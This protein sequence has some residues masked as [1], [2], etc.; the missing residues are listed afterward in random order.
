[1]KGAISLFAFCILFIKLF[2]QPSAPLHDCATDLLYED[3]KKG[4]PAYAKQEE[5]LESKY[6]QFAVSPTVKKGLAQYT[7]P[8]V[9]HLIH[10]NGP[11][12]ISDAQVM[13]GLAHLNQAFQNLGPYHLD[14][15]VSV[16]LEFCLAQRDPNGNPTNGII[17]YQSPLTDMSIPSNQGTVI[18][19]ASW[20]SKE[21]IN[22]RLVKEACFGSNNCANVAGFAYGPSSHGNQADGI[23]MEASYFGSMVAYS[24]VAIHEIGHY[25]G[26][27]HTFAGGCVNGD[28]LLDGDRVCDTP[29]DNQTASKPCSVISN[30]CETDEDDTSNNN[31]FRS[32]SLGGLGEQDDLG[33][34]FMDYIFK[35]C[36]RQ[37]TEGQK[38]RMFFFLESARSSL[39]TSKAC[40]PPCPSLVVA[41]FYIDA[42]TI[43][44]GETL[45]LT[46]L[47]S[48]ASNYSWY[49]NDSLVSNAVNPLLQIS[50][51]GEHELRLVAHSP[52]V[53][54]DNEHQTANIVVVC[55]VTANFSHHLS[56]GW[57]VFEEMPMSN[58]EV[59]WTIKDATGVQLFSSNFHKDSIP[60]NG[61]EYIQLC[62]EVSNG[63]CTNSVCEY[64]NLLGNGIEVCN[65]SI[66]DDGDSFIDDYDQDC[67]CDNTAFQAYCPTDCE[68]VP[69]QFASFQMKLKWK[70]APVANFFGNSSNI[71]V[72]DM[73]KDGKVEILTLAA[74]ESG[75][76]PFATYAS[77]IRI[78]DGA[79][80]NMISEL[81]AQSGTIL[82]IA[83]TDLD[84]KVEI[85]KTVEDTIVRHEL[86]GS[87]R[88][89]SEKLIDYIG[90]AVNLA[91]FEGDGSPEMYV[92]KE[93]LTSSSGKIIARGNLSEGC[94]GFL[95][96][97][98]PCL[99]KHT[100]AADLLPSPGLELAAGNVVY[101]VNIINENGLTGNT[102]TPIMAPS[103]VKDG[104][105]SVGDIN[106]DG[107]L[108]VIVVRD[109]AYWPDNGGVFVW[110]PRNSTLIA[111]GQAGYR[112]GLAFIGDVTG[113]CLPEIGVAFKYELRMYRYNGTQQLQLMYSLPTT[114]ESGVT[115]IT[116]FDFN[117]D[118][119]Q[120]LVYRDETQ[121]RIFEGATGTTL[122]SYPLL[123][124]TSLEYPVVADIDNDGQAEILIN[125][126]EDSNNIKE[127]IYCFE[128]A[129]APWA[130]ARSVWNQYGYHVTNVNDDLTIPRQQQN[131][132]Q[133]LVG[134]EN[135]LQP[136]CP[137]PYNAFLAQATYRTQQGC[138]QFPAVDLTVRALGY[139]CSPDSQFVDLVIGNLSDSG[140]DSGCVRV[141]YYTANPSLGNA[142]P[143]GTVCVP[144]EG[145]S[146]G[147]DTVR[148]GLELPLGT[149]EV[150]FV[151]N[152]P[153]TGANAANHATTGIIECDYTNNMAAVQVQLAP[154]SLSL[155][156][157]IVKCESEVVTLDAGPGFASYAWS[158]GSTEQAYSSSFEGLHFVEALD[159]CQRA[160]RDTMVISFD[161]SLD[162]DLG[163]DL[164]ACPNDT[165]QFAVGSG[166]DMV[167]WLSTGALPCTDC[168]SLAL[169]ADSSYSL[170]VV[171]GKAS[172][173]SA[174]TVEVSTRPR[175]ETPQAEAICEGE[176]L[177]YLG[178]DYTL[179]GQYAIPLNQC[180]ST[181]LLSLSVH[182]KDTTSLLS[183]IC[184]GDSLLFH[185][186]HLKT[187]G[188]Y[189]HTA[190]NQHG[191]D[192]LVQLE[193][194]VLQSI[195][196]QSVVNACP[197]DSVFVLGQW[198]ETGQSATASY[199]TLSGCDSLVTVMAMP[200]NIPS[201][202]VQLSACT[203]DSALYA[204]ALVP[205]GASQLFTLPSF[206]GCDSLV[207]VSVLELPHS[208]SNLTLAACPGD[209]ALYAGILVPAG[210]AQAFIF[211]NW[212]GC[213]STVTVTVAELPTSAG[214]ANFSACPGTAVDF[215]GVMV[216][217]G[218]SQVVPLDNWQGCDSLV[219]VTVAALPA[220]TSSLA[221]SACT[222][223]FADYFGQLLAAGST[224]P[225]LYPTAQGCDSLVVVA[226]AE[227][228]TSSDTVQLT[229]CSGSF[230][231]YNGQQVPA[232]E[233]EDF[234][235][236]NWLNCDSVVTV[237]VA[238]LPVN[239]HVLDTA[240]CSND[241]FNFNGQMVAPGTQAVFPVP[242]QWGCMD[243]FFVNVAALP[244]ATGQETLVA[245]PGTLVPYAGE[246]LAP[247]QVKD[248]PFSMAN[249]CDS[250]VTVTVVALPSDTV[251]QAVSVC[252]GGTFDFHGQMLGAGEQS[253]WVGTDQ[254]NCDSVVVVNVTA[255]PIVTF[256]LSA[257]RICLDGNDGEIAVEQIEGSTPPYY[258]ALGNGSFQAEPVFGGLK[259]GAYQV[260]LQ[261]AN[262][263]VFKENIEL[264][265]YP[266]LTV[267]I[268]DRT[269][270]CDGDVLLQPNVMSD[271]PVD[272]QWW[273]NDSLLS[274]ESHLTINAPGIY[275]YRV[276][277]DCD[278]VIGQVKVDLALSQSENLVYLPGAFSPNGDG[279]NDCFKGYF[280]PDIDIT[281]FELLV[282]DR[283]GSLVFNGCE[284][285][286]CWD[287]SYRGKPLDSMIYVYWLN[288]TATDC[289][290]KEQ[291]V[292]LKDE[293]LLVR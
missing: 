260:S 79:S 66:D 127:R 153:G 244:T 293:I 271:L 93:I 27:W 163:P 149:S 78:L 240:V 46:N 1:M 56:N 51:V 178:V 72:G 174:D 28:C 42:D 135:C 253:W 273:E 110:D 54:C 106:G 38:E 289:G 152:D 120:E 9:V 162:V 77:S 117:Q 116:M 237:S 209:S 62:L 277:N 105:T 182:P 118:G 199:T 196:S 23:V 165:L 238:A 96:T 234:T 47:S 30:S 21:Y 261:D 31:P 17:R 214:T 140:M 241:F 274:S 284:K 103:Q 216:M 189:Y 276:T 250:V 33:N 14:N 266:P 37:F 203:G 59:A 8:V 151:V 126:F 230:A 147:E 194:S 95:S 76:F 249:G 286:T 268:E 172:C 173:F 71:V 142:A 32:Q 292:F 167:Q 114:D 161:H 139:A 236:S 207:T 200:F 98:S 123:S 272:W 145:S 251:F 133:P 157:D 265:A 233:N 73:D 40:L 183:S 258:F 132:A 227:L 211:N 70:S 198:L 129:D 248:F 254:F 111:A 184:T 4:D 247:G 185:G 82:S 87:I 68:Y 53:E 50:Q 228:P 193:L 43:N 210:S 113:D 112:G 128:S 246:L 44:A 83:D 285:E 3:L 150:F 282:F 138:V 288:M 187:T 164:V 7:L 124:A 181:L 80:G 60:T 100:I 242:N 144:F 15:G 188:T 88:Y 64:I 148:I 125:G 97:F 215:Y 94:T 267:E 278:T 102:M 34:N 218:T 168:T 264:A 232:G 213:D 154:L 121:L 252:Q 171:V 48:N 29:P 131:Q 141:S 84:G 11:E 2:G 205:A 58:H 231:I 158:D 55:P 107:E 109:R 262:D 122:A 291:E 16:G 91:D 201:A 24:T 108:D 220:P 221:L 281:S 177:T 52:F 160:Y 239:L 156:P 92:G 202:T 81:D 170:T 257:E 169:A 41:D 90:Q 136:T 222:G 155:G 204:G 219:T 229:A 283:W 25:L 35:D 259:P 22:I 45:L 74:V 119:K 61:L 19:L 137:A 208:F 75:T 159:Q 235:F 280:A 226:V 263:C 275:G 13:Q 176:S 57:L 206:Q 20:N 85:F 243:T 12:N 86:N 65:N 26:L 224:T 36:R 99:I 195:A 67:P 101:D 130:P 179:A 143:L 134:H 217:A 69:A 49:L 290:G 191:C 166:Y 6:R 146:M 175:V 115:G 10:N 270:P 223:G 39:L 287:G 18:S 104:F 212:Q 245:C 256:G 89:K 197:G 5:Y 63:F 180:D 192:S 255:Y 269:I 279:V 225:F 190:T 186:S